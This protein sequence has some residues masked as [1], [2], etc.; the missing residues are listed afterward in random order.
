MDRP[1]DGGILMSPTR[2]NRWSGITATIVTSVAV[3]KKTGSGRPD[4]LHPRPVEDPDFSGDGSSKEYRR[5]W[6]RLIQNIYQV[7]P[8]ICHKCQGGMRILAFIEDEDVIKKILKHLGMW[9]IKARPPSKR[10]NGPPLNIHIDSSHSQIPPEDYLYCD[11]DY[12]I[13]M[14]AS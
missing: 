13:E 6:A 4:T 8:L 10:A 9:S 11:P 3:R 12:P 14:C 1:A 2:E 7:N 5:N